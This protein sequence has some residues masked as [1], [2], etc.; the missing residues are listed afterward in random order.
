MFADEPV[1]MSGASVGITN[2]IGCLAGQ[3]TPLPLMWLA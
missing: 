3:R 2:M 1:P